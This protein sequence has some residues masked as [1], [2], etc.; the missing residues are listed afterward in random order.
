MKIKVLLFS[1]LF[2]LLFAPTTDAFT[3]LQDLGTL[4]GNDS[5]AVAISDNGSVAGWA[6][7][8]S[9]QQIGVLW[10]GGSKS[11]L[12]NLG[13]CCTYPSSINDNDQIVGVS[14]V[15]SGINHAFLWENNTMTDLGTL[16]GTYSQAN[17]INNKGQIVGVAQNASGEWHG[18]LWENGKMTSFD[19]YGGTTSNA[20]AIND[21]GQV[22]IMTNGGGRALLWQNGETTDLGTLG[23]CCTLP[24]AINNNGQIVGMSATTLHDPTGQVNTVYHAF[25]WQN[26]KMQDLGN[27]GSGVSSYAT[28]INNKGEVTVASGDPDIQSQ[29]QS[30]IVNNGNAFPIGTLGGNFSFPSGINNSGKIV[31]WSYLGKNDS[32]G[33]PI[34]HG[35]LLSTQ[36]QE[37]ASH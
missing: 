30:F 33:D 3:N 32:D 17:Q 9:G 7:D 14:A 16:G 2:L 34:Y 22:V 12:G 15:S 13:A 11:M 18:F 6:S 21:L 5:S 1:F 8:I 31:G 37:G 29:G 27:P 24:K 26:G 35:F 25:M 19:L 10:K 4:G 20:V 23:G 36:K 28:A